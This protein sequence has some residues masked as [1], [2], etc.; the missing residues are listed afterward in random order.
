MENIII[1]D[2]RALS[3]SIITVSTYELIAVGAAVITKIITKSLPVKLKRTAIKIT[4]T[5]ITQV[6]NTAENI[7]GLNL[8]FAVLKLNDPPITIKARGVEIEPRYWRGLSMRN[9]ILMLKTEKGIPNK[10]EIIKG[11]FMTF[12]KIFL[13][14]NF[15]F[16]L[17]LKDKMRTERAL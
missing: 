1:F 2:A 11:F 6:F 4:I 7:A 14:L 5:G 8:S 9:G 13:I 3:P 16:F 15:F 10:I 12:I 17:D